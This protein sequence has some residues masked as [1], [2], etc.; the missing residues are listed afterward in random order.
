MI[1]GRATCKW[2]GCV[3]TTGGIVQHWKHCLKNPANQP[4]N[5]N[6]PEEKKHEVVAWLNKIQ[7]DFDHS[8]AYQHGFH[9]AIEVVKNKLSVAKADE[10]DQD[11][12]EGLRRSRNEYMQGFERLKEENKRLQT[13]IGCALDD[14]VLGNVKQAYNILC[15]ALSNNQI[16][17]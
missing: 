14:M 5:S 8:E 13:F 1:I 15:E 4:D 9:D 6:Q 17:E 12:I 2:C 7:P 11:L 3:T 10:V 16:K